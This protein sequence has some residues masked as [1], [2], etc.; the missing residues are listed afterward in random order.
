MSDQQPVKP[1]LEE[2]LALYALDRLPEALSLATR[3]HGSRPAELPPLNLMAICHARLGELE[4]AGHCWRQALRLKPDS[5]EIHNN[6]GNL[7]RERQHPEQAVACYRRALRLKPDHLETYHNLGTLLTGDEAIALWR[8]GV[9][10]FPDQ[11]DFHY[12]LTNLLRQQGRFQE[13]ETACRQLARLRPRHADTHYN[14]GVLL[15]E[16][17]RDQEAM[18]AFRRALSLEPNHLDACNNLALLLKGEK[19]FQ[20]AETVLRHA[21]TVRPEATDLRWNLALLLLSLGRFQEGWPLYAARMEPGP[22][23]WRVTP[24][25]I[26][27]PMWQGEDLTGKSLLVMHEQGFGDQIQFCRYLTRLKTVFGCTLTLVCP[28]PLAP[29]LA[30]LDGV[31][32]LL[33]PRGDQTYPPHDFWVFLLSL[34]RHLGEF[35]MA[36]PYLQAPADRVARWRDLLPRQGF[37]VG[38]V[39]K[40]APDH[41]NDPN[42]S[43]PGLLPLAP[44]WAVPE[45]VFV[46]LQTGVGAAEAATPPR[47]QPLLHL[48]GMLQDF[49]DTAAIVSQLDLVISIDTALVHVAG[50][51]GVPCWVL[52]PARNTDWR[53]LH[54]RED[55]PWYGAGMRLFRQSRPDDWSRVIDRAGEALADAVPDSA[56][57]LYGQGRPHLALQR[58]QG[59]PPTPERLNL[60]AACHLATGDPEQALACW[61]QALGSQPDHVEILN[62]LGMLLTGMQ[63]FDQAEAPLRQALA[64]QPDFVPARYNLGLLRAG[65]N[66]VPEAEEAYRQV[67][68]RQPDHVGAGNN[69]ALL[70]TGQGRHPEAET[71]LRRVLTHDPDQADVWNNLGYLLQRRNRLAE[72]E[73]AF[74]R[75]IHLQPEHG[76]A[77]NNLGTLLCAG[78]RFDQAEAAFRQTLRLQP[79][80]CAAWNNLGNLL[81]KNG[82][83]QEAEKVFRHLL[84]WRPDFA[85]AWNSL[86]LLLKEQNRPAEAEAALRRALALEPDLADAN[87]NLGT[88][89]FERLQEPQAEAAFLRALR[90]QPDHAGA[91]NNLGSLLQAQHRFAAAET[92]FLRALELK[93]DCMDTR[94]NLSLL[95]LTL[96]RFQEGWPLHEA[97]H[98]PDK[99]RWRVTRPELPFPWWRG[100]DLTGKS[101]LVL[102]EQ[103]FGDQIQFARYLPVLKARGA[104]R[105]TLVCPAALAPLLASLEGL[106][107]LLI[108]ETLQGY[109]P[110]DFCT[111][112]LSIPGHLDLIPDRIPYLRPPAERL[113]LWEARLPSSG[114]RVGLVWKGDPRHLND[115]HRSLPD[116]HPLAP[117]WSVPG[118]GFVSLQKDSGAE[119]ARRA[120]LPLLHLGGAIRDFGDTA[121]IVARLDLVITIDSAVAHLTGALGKRCWVMLPGRKTDWRWLHARDDSPWYPDGMR[122]FRQRRLDDW[123]GVVQEMVEQLRRLRYSENPGR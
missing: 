79:H 16:L 2:A 98:H 4:Q 90:S 13:A 118:V 81:Q 48:G 28:A 85:P 80:H 104:A 59:A 92:A 57:D 14:H 99:T 100:E 22:N 36:L 39:W 15:K 67:L 121:A 107:Q 116:L 42:R 103:G 108:L 37:R 25:Q 19:R 109:P 66:R 1:T 40:G 35:P 112:L 52:L 93:P 3:L 33:V 18:A 70:L 97:R 38:L 30:S 119:E 91:C 43:L 51:L 45:V 63:R 73:T 9:A 34:P 89:L 27:C 71:V 110:H 76:E 21:L 115:H 7:H 17:H 41:Q 10:F 29:L 11:A 105:L 74:R 5:A 6:L 54:D 77:H 64:R 95:Y 94:W 26:S 122:L 49:A 82:R 114:L 123:S 111:L 68:A 120:P 60:A 23:P 32:R 50:A 20:E 44:L 31:D 88:L 8:Q 55:S 24:I 47:D 75:A 46:S 61:R 53:W 87:N 65:Q 84:E 78:K 101:L 62:N 12:Q 69:L 83:G 72:A 58:L 117:L 96:G 106:D 102:P 113:P 86:G 56:F